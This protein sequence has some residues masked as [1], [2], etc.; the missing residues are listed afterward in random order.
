[1]T[2]VVLAVIVL[3]LH[4]VV[5][6]EVLPAATYVPVNIA[7]GAALFGIALGAGCSLAGLGLARS[8]LPKGVAAGAVAALL[9][10]V[11]LAL[12]AA[13]PAT[14]VLFEDRRVANVDGAEL[15]Y[16]AFVRIPVGTAAFEELAFR[17][18]LLALLLRITSTVPAVMASSVLFGLWH[19][20]PTL[21]ALRVNELA[22]GT[23]ARLGAVAGAVIATAVAGGLFCWLR[24]VT[25]SL[26]APM[27]AHT[28]T[29][30]FAIVT[31]YAVLGV[32]RTPT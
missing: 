5:G 20:L 4:N 8:T 14:R 16:Q 15:V 3:A 31:A 22:A 29:N 12:A 26:V 2:W 1:M 27:I 7:T 17:G 24:L 23:G 19:V 28:A 6:N 25:G 18:V 30:S 11:V 13:I 10:A 32:V 9:V 21:S